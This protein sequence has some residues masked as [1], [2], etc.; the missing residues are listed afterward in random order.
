[1]REIVNLMA[2]RRSTGH[3]GG[4]GILRADL[5]EQAALADLPRDVEMI[6]R[7]AERTGHPAAPRIEIDHRGAWNLREQSL[8]SR[9]QAHRL[10]MAMP[11]Q[12]DLRGAL[13][14]LQ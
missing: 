12:Q 2:A 14:E 13:V 7:V 3:H 5:R 8:R 10:L 6:F 11:V 4:V 9:Q 1:M